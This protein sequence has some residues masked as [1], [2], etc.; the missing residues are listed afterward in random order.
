MKRLIL[1]FVASAL[2]FGCKKNDND[3]A[4]KN[5]SRISFGS[6]CA[7]YIADKKIFDRVLEKN[8][9]LHIAAGDNIYGDFFA[10]LPGTRE[11]MEGAYKQLG[12]SGSFKNLKAAVPILPI[13]D[14]HDTGEND[15]T[16]TNPVKDIAK[17]LFLKF[18]GIPTTAPRANR[19]S[20]AI[21]DSYFYGDDAH[22]VQVILL[23][24]RWN[25]SPYKAS[26]AGAA[27]E[28]YDTIMNPNA[29]MLGDD[30]WEWL[31]GELKK[32]AKVRI[33]VS[34]F[35]FNSL[36]NGGE[37]WA[38]LPLEQKRMV[39][40]LK[41]TQANGVI[42]ISGDVHYAELTKVQYDGMYPIYEL[43][44]SGITH[45]EDKVP[46]TNDAIRVGNGWQYVNFGFIDIDWNASPVA[47][48]LQVY[49]NTQAP[50]EPQI[51]YTVTLDELQF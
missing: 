10:L 36:Y 19:P 17:E 13:W 27:L 12:T 31:E 39:D 4:D 42:F 29:T 14:D 16:V 22:R 7:Q 45:H 30:Q 23:D 24:L 40:L 1:L 47:I 32:P 15:A 21:Y 28:G 9:Q 25:H 26:G 18:W 2:F 3:N 49:G 11:Y 38:L 35:Q 33:I 34:S 48:K 50:L 43:T 37:N 5:L 51:N 44:S 8:P 41:S 20:G 6:C 46:S